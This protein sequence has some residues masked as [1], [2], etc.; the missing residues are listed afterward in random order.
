MYYNPTNLLAQL[1]LFLLLLSF[2]SCS[3][4]T[5]ELDSEMSEVI[6]I[7]NN[8][9]D[10]PAYIYG[11]GASKVFIILIHGGPGGNGLE[12][13]CGYFSEELEA[14]YAMVYTDQRGQGSSHGHYTSSDMNISQM[15][16]DLQVLVL[17]LKAEYGSDI[18][19]FLLGHS[20]GG[21]LGTAYM[22]EKDYQ[23]EINGWIEANGAH[24]IPMLNEE[25]VDMFITIGEEQIA[26]NKNVDFWEEVLDAVS[27]IPDGGI[28]VDEGG[29]I[30]LYAHQAETKLD[31]VN[32][33]EGCGKGPLQSIFF[34][35]TNPITTSISGNVA[36]SLLID[37]I[38]QLS[39]TNQ[40]HKITTPSLF[41]WGKYD[42][43]VPPALG[44][45]AL[46]KVSSEDKE[47]F[48]FENSGHSPMDA[49]PQAFTDAIIQFV[50]RNR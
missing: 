13:R 18:S 44:V 15:V 28:T 32:G 26:L 47:L 12:Y 34:S 10:I 1:F 21:E 20:W 48:I 27:D 14:N 36:S 8:G 5:G 22:V 50:E 33:S 29:T 39:Y 3:T 25:A 43:V 40:L 37:E 6:H 11:N 38:D 7:R 45:S 42:F 49:E 23:N 9:A 35:P 24:D 4:F 30:N 19:V 41:L 16:E 31:E 17:T 46:E 2:T